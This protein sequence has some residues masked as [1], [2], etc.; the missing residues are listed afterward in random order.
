[1]TDITVTDVLAWQDAASRAFVPLLCT[2]SGPGF[3]A[4]LESVPL[5]DGVSLAH[6]RSGPLRVERTERLARQSDGDDLL[7]SLQLQSSGAVHQHGR[8]AALVPGTAA[9]YEIN[10]PYLL[11][12]PESGQDLIVLRVRREQLGLKSRFVSDLCGRTIDQSVPGMAAFTG[13]VAGLV[14][15]R[16]YMDGRARRELGH[17]STDLLSLALRSFAGLQQ[18]A[19]DD[20]QTLLESA[21]AHIRQNLADPDLS[22]EQLARAHNVSVRKLHAIFSATGITPGAY[23]RRLRLERAAALIAARAQTHQSVGAIAAACGFRDT[24]TFTRA[25]TRAYD[26]TP[27]QW[28]FLYGQTNNTL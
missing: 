18:N 10:R 27:T 17:I 21:K 2:A 5:S 23:I 1:M 11:E 7:M 6:V 22:V 16:A 28:A 8:T 26:R 15:G 19:W 12:Q 14:T 25:F 3:V 24:S 20:D 13:Y 9:L 4:H